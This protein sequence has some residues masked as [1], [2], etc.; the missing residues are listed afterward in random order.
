MPDSMLITKIA[1]DSISLELAN[2][3]V[4]AKYFEILCLK[5]FSNYLYY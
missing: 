4:V 5:M 3:Q 2:K 1:D